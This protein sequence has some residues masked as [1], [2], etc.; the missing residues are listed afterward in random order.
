MCIGSDDFDEGRAPRCDGERGRASLELANAIAL[1]SW[2]GRPVDLPLD[3][4]TY[5]EAL[6]AKLG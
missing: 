6:A 1:S 3:R 5:D 2:T 4:A